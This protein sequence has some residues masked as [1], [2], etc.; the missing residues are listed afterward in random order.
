[1]LK[2]GNTLHF[3]SRIDETNCGDRLCSPLLYYKDFFKKYN[4]KCHDIRY[5]DFGTISP[6]DVVIIG[7]G[8]LIDYSEKLNRN[9]NG[10]LET[11]AAVIMWAAGLNTHDE[12]DGTFSTEIEYEKFKRAA[13]RD[14]TNKHGLEYLPDVSC[15]LPG[16]KKEYTIRRKYG[17]ARHKDYPLPLLEE[18]DSI[19]NASDIEDILKFIGESEIILSNS[20]HL[21]YWSLLMGKK[22]ICVD[23]FSSKFDSYKYKPEYYSS[24]SDNLEECAAKAKSYDIIDECIADNDSFFEFVKQIIEERLIPV[25][26]NVDNISYALEI[27]KLENR[28]MEQNSTGDTLSSQLFIDTGN[29]F[30]ETQKCIAINNI[31]GDEIC[32]VRFDISRYDNICHLRFDPI[33]GQF[34]EVEIIS[35]EDTNGKVILY[36]NASVRYG[37]ADRFLTTDPQ[38]FADRPCSGVLEIKFRFRLISCSETENNIMNYIGSKENQLQEILQRADK[39]T[40][41]VSERDEVIFN[42]S[43]SITELTAMCQQREAASIQLEQTIC[44]QNDRISSFEEKCRWYAETLTSKDQIINEQNDCISSFEEKCRWYA[45]TLT[46]K[47]Q[48]V[49]E[50]EMSINS[51]NETVQNRE[52]TV[53]QQQKM[54]EKQNDI[55]EQVRAELEQKRNELDSL[56]QSKSWKITS[57]LRKIVDFFR[58]ILKG[59]KNHEAKQ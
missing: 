14:C 39:L 50:Q 7:G 26:S 36:P 25:E 30:T 45:E 27:A 42:Q 28:L 31:I 18:Y 52:Q 29:G 32:S 38:Y 4:I 3:I 34:C 40:N 1:M 22:T 59:N 11:G 46:A 17:V 41:T 2:P 21:I 23:S 37:N 10:A 44:N 15:K 57:P 19:T 43:K 51:L 54:I 48:T 53:L 56:Y 24:S 47:D 16:L 55:L 49:N 12:F 6:S 13:V 20:F 8:G 9:I 35:A 5:V 58:K 33:E